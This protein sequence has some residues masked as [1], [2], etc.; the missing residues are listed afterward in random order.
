M[1]C[2]VCGQALTD[3]T[4]AFC[5]K[6][7]AAKGTQ[8]NSSFNQGNPQYGAYPGPQAGKGKA[9]ASLILGIAAMTIP[10]PVL[11]IIL[12]VVGI[13]LAVSSKN[14]GFTGGVRVGGFVCSIIGT[15]WATIY[16]IVILSGVAMFAMW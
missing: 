3:T 4:G 8:Q 14:D 15:I 5:P 11:D 12:G 9:I 6:C 1:F 2:S 16:T 7:G 13:I 10:V